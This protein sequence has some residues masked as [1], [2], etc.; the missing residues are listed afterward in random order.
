MNIP[1]VLATYYDNQ[2]QS[3]LG[4]RRIRDGRFVPQT[5]VP[6]AADLRDD[7]AGNVQNYRVTVNHYSLD[8]GG[9]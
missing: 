5:P 7:V 4:S 6:F 3:D 9:L 8:K 1:H 2:R